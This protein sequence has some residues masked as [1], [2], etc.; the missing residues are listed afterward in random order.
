[1]GIKLNPLSGFFDLVGGG[2]SLSIGADIAGSTPHAILRVS[3]TSQLD[4]IGPLTDGQLIIGV[5]GGA[6]VL[7]TISGTANQV[8]VTN[9]AGTISLSLPQDIHTGASPTF[10]SLNLDTVLNLSSTADS[11][12]LAING[13]NSLEV[14]LDTDLLISGTPAAGANVVLNNTDS[15]GQ[16]IIGTDDLVNGTYLSLNGTTNA[17][18]R[19]FGFYSNTGFGVLTYDDASEVL[20][21]H[22][23]ILTVPNSLELTYMTDGVLVLNG[24]AVINQA[25]LSVDLG[26]TGLDGSS[27][28]NGQ[29]LIGNG[30]GYSLA[31]ITGTT[32]QVSVTNGAGSITLSL[33]QDIAITST[34][35]FS[36]VLVSPAGGIDTTGVGTLAIGTGNADII[37]IGN[38]GVTVNIQG[39]TFYQ[40]V[41]NLQVTDKLITINKGGSAGSGSNAGI[42]IEE[43]AVITGYLDTTADRLGWEFKAPASVGIATIAP[44]ASGFT[45]DQGSHNPITLGAVGASPNA[46][47]ASLNTQV[48]NLEPASASFPGVVTISAQSFSGIKTFEDGIDV[49]GQAITSVLDPV[50]LQDAAT[51]NYVDNEISGLFP[52][53]LTADVTG[54]LPIANGGTNLSSVG[55]ANELLSVNLGGTALE[56]RTIIEGAGIEVAYSAGNI[57]IDNLAFSADDVSENVWTGIADNTADQPITGL[58]FSNTVKYFDAFVDVELDVGNFAAATYK[59]QARRRG[60]DWSTNEIQVDYMGD[61]LDG[62][63]FTIDNTGQV[64]VTTPLISGFVSGIVTFRAITLS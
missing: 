32:D 1:M 14:K 30:T 37:N 5:S 63:V 64:L 60:V 19:S 33:P 25:Q 35:T 57:Q 31:T 36:S 49:N 21:T 3:G 59:V 15:D 22:D 54:V 9:G 27:A 48:L 18:P 52:I 47:G 46:N 38:S 29:L 61:F 12:V 8:T 6:A 7:S 24:S 11:L 23:T 2:S 42:E 43:N 55:A 40:N 50:A 41:T 4:E 56:Y 10:L 20:S 16:T 45:I 58:A 44:G 34:P 28:A 53:D 13:D 39:D 62:V 51:K 26:G 17:S